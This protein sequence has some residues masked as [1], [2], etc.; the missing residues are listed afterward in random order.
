MLTSHRKLSLSPLR[1]AGRKSEI[2]NY[3]L[4]RPVEKG[5]IG[6]PSRLCHPLAAKLIDLRKT[7]LVLLG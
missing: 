6:K 4:E 7:Q 5:G 2:A 3:H 1:G